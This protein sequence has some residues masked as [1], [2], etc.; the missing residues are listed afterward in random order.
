M[1]LDNSGNLGIGTTTISAPNG[2][3]YNLQIGTNNSGSSSEL[4]L[5]HQGDGFSLFTSGGSGG[6]ALSFSQGTSEKMRI[7]FSG[8][9]GIGTSSPSQKLDVYGSVVVSPNTA[10]KNTFT[11]TTNASNDGRLLI[12]SVDTTT[13]DIQANGSS[14]FNGGKVGIG[15]TSPTY[16]LEVSGAQNANDI[17]ST[18]TTT[19]ASLRM[20]MIDGYGSI[21]TTASYPFTFGTNNTEA[22][23]L[24]SSGN[25]L[26]GTTSATNN[27]Y[28]VTSKVVV[29][30]LFTGSQTGQSIT[31]TDTNTSNSHYFMSFN[32]GTSLGNQ[33]GYIAFVGGTGAVLYS[34]T[35]DQRLKTDLGVVTETS[36]I[37][38]LLIHDY[39]WKE[40]GVK[41][42]G[43][44]AQEAYEVMPNAIG[45]GR[46]AEDGSINTPWGV[47]YSKFVPDLIVHAQQLKKQVQELNTLV[48]TQS[49]EI[50]ALKQKVGI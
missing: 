14:Y 32:L 28:T 11:L 7:D 29:S 4:L 3:V 23:R 26:V 5:G 12:K 21:F 49:A 39:T 1:T 43:V 27:P 50:A 46:D 25:L 22:M 38:N 44:F 17:V 40:D 48:T 13:V 47:D 2:R 18:N 15:T 34:T 16:K 10:G 33:K 36:V 45:K 35:S 24:D 9:V 30:G 37:D 8:N 19:S 42:R 31:D 6:G 20:Q 41:G